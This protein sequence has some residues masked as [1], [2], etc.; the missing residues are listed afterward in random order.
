MNLR[1]GFGYDV[2]QLAKGHNLCLGGIVI[3]HKKGTVGHSDGDVLIHSICDALLGAANLHDI[4][5]HFPDNS[6]EYKGI[7]SKIL[8]QKTIE[9]LNDK[10]YEIIN[11]DSTICLEEPKIKDSIPDMKK[12]LAGVMKQ[13][14]ENISIKATTS[15]KM[16]FIGKTNGIAAY[17]IALIHKPTKEL[18]VESL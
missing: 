4:G 7:D 12:I 13:N 5:Y 16:G 11:I 3:P 14:V 6:E 18:K 9:L 15:E 1:I 2:H 8:L 10:D 17:A